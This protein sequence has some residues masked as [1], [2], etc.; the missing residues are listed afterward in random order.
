MRSEKV[1]HIR[2]TMAL[3]EVRIS[4]RPVS[5]NNNLRLSHSQESPIVKMCCERDG[6]RGSAS[7]WQ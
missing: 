5:K 1:D 7:G 2:I 4:V 6:R 3:F